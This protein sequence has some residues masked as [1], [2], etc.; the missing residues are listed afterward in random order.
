VRG[1]AS[2]RAR[3]VLLAVLALVLL[4]VQLGR[5]AQA[6]EPGDE[7]EAPAGESVVGTLLDGERQPVEG[8]RFEVRSGD[9]VIGEATSDADGNW[10]VPVPEPGVYVVEIDT[11]TLPDGVDLRDPD[12][13]VLDN[14]S[15][16]ADQAKR[17]LFALGAGAAG[18]STAE[19]IADLVF[20]GIRIG[21]LLALMSVGLSL[22]FG[23]SGLTNF[24]HGELVTF[25]ALVAFLL[26]SSGVSTSVPLVGAAVVATAAGGLFGLANERLLFRPL[27]RRRT[28]TVALIVVTIGLSL[29]LRNV[30]LILFGGQPR[31]YD[32]FTVQKG[33]DLPL[34]SP[35][36]KDLVVMA[37]AIV[38][39][40]AYAL[41][42]QRTRIGTATRAVADSRELAEATGI[43]VQWVM[44]STWVLAGALAALG[45]VLWG[46]TETITSDMGFT[47]LLLMFATVILGGIG[48]PFGPLVG[49]LVIGVA[50]QVSTYW[51][52]SKLRIGVALAVLIIVIL[53]RPQGILGKRERIG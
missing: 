10:S 16:R 20:D 28:G 39:M 27:R 6:Q 22:V 29:V 47:L 46:V 34:V 24:A 35:E 14:V 49:G 42:I 9:D 15:V 5:P 48:T 26:A 36:P 37:V 2:F 52:D 12:R 41:L 25:G 19:Q 23:V 4:A 31:P 11:E 50:S 40:V 30:Y 43:D 17:V 7:P 51:I 44:Q 1:D 21:L 3:T 38:A 45:G 13:T 8:V 18:I 33:I 53:V 32:E